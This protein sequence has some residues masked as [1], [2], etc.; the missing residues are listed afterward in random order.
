[1]TAHAT[2]TPRGTRLSLALVGLLLIGANLRAGITAVGPV[3]DDLRLDLGLSSS[4][5]SALISVPL[6]A[7]A[8]LSPVAPAVARRFGVERVL[9]ASLALLAVSI[10]VRSAPWGVGTLSGVVSL[11]VGTAGL[12]VA[13][14]FLNVVLPVLVKRDH[15]DRIGAMT[16]LYS[17][18]QSAAA[19]VAAGLAVPI[20]GTVQH[21]WRLSLGIWAG[22]AL[23]GLA[24]FLPRMRRRAAV[25]PPPAPTGSPGAPARPIWRSALAWQVTVFMGLQSTVYYTLI[26]FL[27]SIEQAVGTSAAAAGWHQFVLQILSIAGALS[28]AALIQ[29]LPDQRPL[30]LA[31]AL[32]CGVGVAGILLVPPLAVLWVAAIGVGVGGGVVFAL[33]LFGL[34]TADHHRAG[35]L[36]GMAQC[37]GYLV[38]AAGPPAI[39]ALHDATGSWTPPLL[40][41]LAMLAVALVAGVLAGR[42]RVL[43]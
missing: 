16:G 2:T 41:V 20:A 17:S 5:A 34:R 28:S 38:A 26:T 42:N 6:V 7:F 1:M 15:P 22:L 8:V 11:W 23:I 9:G 33:S 12:G 10:V 21:G 31:Y 29:R 13:V 37:L 18:V 43:A 32:L 27:P 39:G 30:A 40:V 25:T 3:L 36:S 4:T 35:T 14:A 19:A 24:V